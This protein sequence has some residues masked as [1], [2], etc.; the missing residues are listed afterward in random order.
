MQTWLILA[1][2]GYLF[3]AVS[4]AIDKYLMNRKYN[5]FRTDTF[6]MFFDG[7][8]LLI[9]CLTF[10]E[11]TISVELL[12]WSFL[13]GTIYALSGIMYFNALR[14]KDAKEVIPSLQSS[15]ILLIFL[16]SI[17]LFNEIVNIFNYF[18]VFL[19][20]IGIY[21][22]LSK[23]LKLPKLDKGMGFIFITI[24]LTVIYSLL[25]KKLLFG[26]KPINLAVTMYFS[27]TFV[28]LLY[29]MFFEKN[30]IKSFVNFKSRI[31]KVLLASL[32]G[33]FGTFLLYS[34]LS[35]GNASKIY[36]LAGLQSVF[37]FIIASLFLKERFSWHRLLGT[38]FV[39]VGVFLV[40]I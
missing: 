6:K 29:Q 36:P 19:I 31:P 5:I 8:I 23:G 14:L 9:I 16:L 32:F 38:L 35:I 24:F 7:L 20:I 27:C 40:S 12:I 21:S 11:F 4:T 17:L 28:L 22:V 26:I 18:G 39:F 25:A 37:I 33:S 1:T 13:L 15:S 10:F 3:Y 34:A 30:I 2:V